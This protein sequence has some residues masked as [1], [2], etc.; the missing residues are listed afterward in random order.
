MS[1]QIYYK[2]VRDENILQLNKSESYILRD[3]L[4]QAIG[5]Q[6]DISRTIQVGFLK[7]K[8][9]LQ[10]EAY[11]YLLY[12][13]QQGTEDPQRGK[14]FQELKLTLLQF[15]DMLRR[16]VLRQYSP[17][18]DYLELEA[19]STLS[20]PSGALDQYVANDLF[21]KI[22]LYG[23]LSDEEYRQFVEFF[24]SKAHWVYKAMAVSA[25]TLSLIGYF[26]VNKV[27]LLFDTIVQ[28]QYQVWERAMIGLIII[29]YIYDK[30]LELYP[31]IINRLKLLPEIDAY[32]E[33]I[34]SVLIQII[35]SAK[36]TEILQERFEKEIVPEISKMAPDLEQKLNLDELISDDMQEEDENP[37]WKK[38]FKGQEDFYEKMSEFTMLQMEGADIMHSAFSKM[39]FFDFFYSLP[40]WFMPFYPDNE[41]VIDRMT[42][43]G[44]PE[45][46]AREFINLLAD[47]H[48]IC[49]SDKYSFSWHLG[50]L[51]VDQLRGMINLFKQEAN[52]VREVRKTEQLNDIL[53]ASRFVIIQY[54][55]DLYRFFKLFPK[56]DAL[57]QIF[58]LPWDVQN[59]KFIKYLDTGNLLRNIGEFYFSKKFYADAI[60]VFEKIIKK[61]NSGELLEK[62]GYS[63]QKLKNYQKALEYYKQAEL[64]EQESQR[65][66]TQKLAF[67][68]MKLGNYQ[69]AI[70]LFEK[71]LLDEP[72]NQKL[73][74]NIGNCYLH[75]EEYD[76]AMQTFF[77][78][79]YY[80]PG[81]PKVMRPIGWIA[82][83]QGDLQKAKKF[84]DKVM[85]TS[86]KYYDFLT[87]GHIYFALN[88]RNKALEL[89]K[90]ALA[91]F[92]DEI[93]NFEK[94]FFGDME[95]LKQYGIDELSANLMF[96]SV[97][98]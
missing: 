31:E 26:D 69:R 46:E 52:S 30:R 14:I 9:K 60:G 87:A 16:F 72:D 44:F 50:I 42:L 91:K 45:D 88:Q 80:S 83:K 38:I 49:N 28:G 47:S 37:N 67:V 92:D 35:R 79:E 61:E 78:V 15:N 74:I 65:W 73:L 43:Y 6:E 4:K 58:D 75:L 68:N 85:E 7:D 21:I 76:K 89:Y 90:Q 97:I 64:F 63:Y 13:F 27:I 56:L 10:K 98:D 36:E 66:L 23:E 81:N 95:I 19:G 5:L 41:Q 18:Y 86:P 84:Y 94:K 48:Y 20:F 93:E 17:Y 71:L 12:Y 2:M 22:W 96:E 53:G 51:P 70:E 57:P 55:Q 24:K 8:L 39:K 25:L 59:T 54:V 82:F 11:N 62:I 1:N 33:K 34:K 32:D 40:N 3:R 29:L 77:K